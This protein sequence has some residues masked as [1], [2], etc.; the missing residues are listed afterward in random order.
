M[1]LI[2]RYTQKHLGMSLKHYQKTIPSLHSSVDFDPV[3]RAKVEIRLPEDPYETMTAFPK[4]QLKQE[5]FDYL[6]Q[7]NATIPSLYQ[8]NLII[9]G[10]YTKE[11][12]ER[13]TMLI[14]RHYDLQLLM[15]QD[16][17]LFLQFKALW[18]LFLGLGVIILMQVVPIF[19]QPLL[20]QV[21]STVG[22]F[23]LWES[24][25]TFILERRKTRHEMLDI[26]QYALSQVTFVED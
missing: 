4:A 2:D 15:K 9:H 10:S 26:A 23:S 1:S 25:D 5:I 11:E 18:L 6:D 8:I 21:V 24:A 14:K 3:G 22:S 13:L 20:Q 12:Q 17:N 19:N 7:R 16:E